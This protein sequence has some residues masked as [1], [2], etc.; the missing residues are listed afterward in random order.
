METNEL[1]EKLESLPALVEKLRFVESSFPTDSEN[2]KR[3]IYEGKIES[4][5]HQMPL[6]ADLAETEVQEVTELFGGDIY[7]ALAAQA[8]RSSHFSDTV[9]ESYKSNPLVADA[10]SGNFLYKRFNRDRKG[11]DSVMDL[12]G[13]LVG[14][15]RP[16][17][18]PKPKVNRGTRQLFA[19]QNLL[20]CMEKEGPSWFTEKEREHPIA[21]LDYLFYQ[22]VERQKNREYR[23]KHNF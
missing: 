20:D 10:L 15:E 9:I 21:F 4:Y 14:N 13:E 2:L 5:K 8:V 19:G 6:F 11:W 23:Q 16:K 22:Y 12:Y 3:V 17:K 7:V 18:C 1:I